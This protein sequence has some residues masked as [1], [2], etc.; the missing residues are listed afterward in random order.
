[1]AAIFII[2][3]TVSIAFWNP[4]RYSEKTR[5]FQER[6]L[7]EEMS[8]E[9]LFPY[10][11]PSDSL[12]MEVK[13]KGDEKDSLKDQRTE[14]EKH[15]SAKPQQKPRRRSLEVG[16]ETLHPHVGYPGNLKKSP[17][18]RKI[19]RPNEDP[20]PISLQK[21]PNTVGSPQE[22]QGNS[23]V[24]EDCFE[25]FLPGRQSTAESMPGVSA[26]APRAQSN[27][28]SSG[29]EEHFPILV[30]PPEPKVPEVLEERSST[31][32]VKAKEDRKVGLKDQKTELEKH[33][34]AKPQQ[35]PRRR[36]L[37]VGKETLHP[38]VGYPGNLKKSPSPRKIK[39]P[40]EDPKS[41]REISL[42]ES[43]DTVVYHQ[44]KQNDSQVAEDCFEGQSATESMP[45]V[46]G[47][48]PGPQRNCASSGTEDHF[49]ILVEL[50][51]PKVPEVVEQRSLKRKV[52][53]KQG[54]KAGL[55]GDI[56]QGRKDEME[57]VQWGEPEQSDLTGSRTDSN[58]N[59]ALM[60]TVWS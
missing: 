50:S 17:S 44:T 24:A 27:C 20:E 43:L 10:L 37:E 57:A 59:L 32:E 30:E 36:S 23:Q 41:S 3:E 45:G 14:L 56:G 60:K 18:P 51:E 8:F 48:A 9:S 28:A 1:M 54:G 31:I 42:Q 15:D 11:S 58:L 40:N 47:E 29:T 52:K 35:K 25:G 6:E 5:L 19:K 2:A 21:F 34:S 53:A 49:P 38:D 55:K 16:R 4:A 39:R 7:L 13:A 12:E 22:E 46:S 33:D 26:E